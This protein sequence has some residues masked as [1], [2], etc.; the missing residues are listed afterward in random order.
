MCAQGT[1]LFHCAD[2]GL[3]GVVDRV[4]VLADRATFRIAVRRPSDD[5]GAMSI[6]VAIVRKGRAGKDTRRRR[7]N[8]NRAI[9]TLALEPSAVRGRYT[10]VSKENLVF[11]GVCEDDV[12]KTK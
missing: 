8:F 10:L 3:I 1:G 6:P 5:E 9:R 11:F 4:V 2:L 7:I 12:G